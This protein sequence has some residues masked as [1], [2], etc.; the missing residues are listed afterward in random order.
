MHSSVQGLEVSKWCATLRTK[1]HFQVVHKACSRECTSKFP[2][3]AL[4][5]LLL[6]IS[7]RMHWLGHLETFRYNTH[8]PNHPLGGRCSVGGQ[9]ESAQVGGQ[10]MKWCDFIIKDLKK[11]D[12]VPDRHDTVHAREGCL[13]G[14]C[15]G[16]RNRAYFFL[17]EAEEKKRWSEADERR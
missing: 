5:L 17:E 1:V 13:E 4:Q 10:K 11:C 14:V 15:E 12:L 7:R 3:C 9:R 6:W 16:C 2:S 8:L